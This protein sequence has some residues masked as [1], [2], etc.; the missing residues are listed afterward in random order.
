MQILDKNMDFF[1]FLLYTVFREVMILD[2]LENALNFGGSNDLSLSYCGKR[3]NTLNHEYG[4]AVRDHFLIIY[5][6]DGT[7]TLFSEQP[8]IPLETGSVFFMFPNH[9]IHYK[10]APGTKWTILWIGIRG[11]L[12]EEYAK[13][14]G[15]TPE[16]PVFRPRNPDR[17]EDIFN[18]I[19]ELSR[20]DNISD[21][22]RCIS[23][24]QSFFAELF[25]SKS[26]QKIKNAHIAAALNI[27]RRKYALGVTIRD[28]VK[29]LSIDQSYFTRAFSKECGV[30]P[31]KW[32]N[33]FRIKKACQLLSLTDMPIN[34][35]S[36][37]VGIP[38]SLY[39][40]RVFKMNVGITPSEY[41]KKNTDTEKML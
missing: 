26:A 12:A 14:L 2:Y 29:E 3:L 6:K 1:D 31:V 39:F 4:P 24:V 18:R 35:I 34:E 13:M 23:L 19:F 20:S 25:E 10:V 16:N 11:K 15:L 32:L 17:I 22:I 21:S 30:P 9:K 33:D 27:M 5:I 40:S 38:D 36:S 37:A 41:R 7:G 28:I 8:N